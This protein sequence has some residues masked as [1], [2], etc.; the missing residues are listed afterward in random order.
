MVTRFTLLFLLCA[1]QN[2][3]SQDDLERGKKLYQAHC[4]LCHGQTGAGG[5][6]PNLAQPT[7][8]HAPDDDQLAK[9]ISEGIRGTEMPGAWQLTGREVRQVGG[10]VRSLGKIAATPLPGDPARGKV[11]YESRGACAGCHIV[12]GKGSSLGPELTDVGARRNAGYLRE[13]LVK[14]GASVAPEFLMI[15]VTTRE[16]KIIAARRLNEDT[17]TIQLRDA[18]G[19]FYSFRKSD[20]TNLKREP[21][22]SLM[23]AYDSKFSAGELDD[24][25]A[26][27]ASLRGES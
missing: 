11:L 23:P 2:A 20:L 7:L 18:A 8:A 17:F 24:V 16:G 5:R 21:N 12:H 27:L 3:W 26:Y 22:V 25:I 4:A 10:Y 1:I 14:P 19:R 9:V 15:S 6:G 13:A